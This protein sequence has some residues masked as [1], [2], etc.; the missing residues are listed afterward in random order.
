MTAEFI[1]DDQELQSPQYPEA[2][3][4]TFT[5]KVTGILIA[6]AGVAGAGYLVWKLVLPA[7]EQYAGLQ[8]NLEPS[9]I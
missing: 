3:G 5:P 2:F 9:R 4:I 7:Q 6:I 8:T 1:I